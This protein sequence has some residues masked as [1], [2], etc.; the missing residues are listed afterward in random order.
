MAVNWKQRRR[1]DNKG[2]GGAVCFSMLVLQR[3]TFDSTYV[4]GFGMIWGPLHSPNLPSIQRARCRS[5]S[6]THYL[7]RH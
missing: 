1:P 2:R 6:I 7:P 4:D 3:P 5:K